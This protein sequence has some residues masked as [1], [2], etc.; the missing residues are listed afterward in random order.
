MTA[1]GSLRRAALVLALPLGAC[2]GKPSPTAHAEPKPRATTTAEPH[3]VSREPLEPLPEVPA[4]DARTVALGRRLFHEPRLSGDG[5][6]ACSSCHDLGKSGADSKPLSLGVS[7]KSGLVN[8][9]TVY[10]ASLNFVQFWDGRAATL[11]DQV[12][13]PITNPIEM[14]SSWDQALAALRAD[15]SY[16]ADFGALPGG[17][18]EANVRRAVA[19][20]ERTLLTRGSAFDRFLAGDEQALAPEARSGYE[21]FKSVGCIACHQGRNVGGNMFQRFGVLGDYFKDRGHVS[22]A[23]Y[24]RYNVTHNE[25]DRYVF[26]VPSL[27]NVTRTAPYFHDGSAATLPQAVQ[28]MARYQLG[29]KLSDEQVSAIIAFLGALAGNQQPAGAKI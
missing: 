23:D 28:V 16:V 15:P 6:V 1:R 18:T 7:G 17:L 24:G 21:M 4:L 27:R 25:A 3:P 10:N 26:R 20:F 19:D 9:P 12:G 8:A 2:H 5:K 13:G 11:E 29:R 22:E 14:G